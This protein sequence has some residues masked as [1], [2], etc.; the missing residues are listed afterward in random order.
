MKSELRFGTETVTRIPVKSSH[1]FCHLPQGRCFGTFHGFDSVKTSSTDY[2]PS[3]F[4]TKGWASQS[5]PSFCPYSNVL[6][7]SLLHGLNGSP[8]SH[9]FLNTLW[10]FQRSLPILSIPGMALQLF[11]SLTAILSPTLSS[12]FSSA[13]LHLSTPT[14][15]Q[16]SNPPF[17]KALNFKTELAVPARCSHST[18]IAFFSNGYT[19]Y[20]LL[21]WD[22][23]GH[24]WIPCSWRSSRQS[25]INL[26]GTLWRQS[27]SVHSE[28]GH[29]RSDKKTR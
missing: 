16:I 12:D 21:R 25:K 27:S 18:Q 1:H 22:C 14:S 24:F 5:S 9:L 23:L 6:S 26:E 15:A 13:A 17:L 8:A 4:T 11:S 7:R 3:P 10:S 28:N 29:A 2:S 20:K 19:V